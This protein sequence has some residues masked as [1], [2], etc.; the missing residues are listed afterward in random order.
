MERVNGLIIFLFGL[1]IFWQGRALEIGGLHQPGPGFF[2]KLIACVLIILSFPIFLGRKTE[3]DEELFSASRLGRVVT[4]LGA[5]IGYF[6]LLEFLGFALSSFCLMGFCF[7]FIGRQRWYA[8]L[9]WAF[10]TTGLA[11]VLFQIL[12]KSELPKGVFGF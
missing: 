5:L 2:P 9:F 1:V 7:L 3:S 11:Y 6:L 10:V 8:G 12:L 4:V